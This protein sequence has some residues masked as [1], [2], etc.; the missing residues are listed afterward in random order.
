VEAELQRPPLSG[1]VYYNMTGWLCRHFGLQVAN[2]TSGDLLGTS[3]LVRDCYDGENNRVFFGSY[4]ALPPFTSCVILDSGPPVIEGSSLCNAQMAVLCQVPLDNV[5]LETTTKTSIRHA[6]KVSHTTVTITDSTTLTTSTEFVL[7]PTTATLTSL[8]TEYGAL[9]VTSTIPHG[10]SKDHQKQNHDRNRNYEKRE[11]A[12]NDDPKYAVC[13]SSWNGYRIVNNTDVQPQDTPQ[14]ACAAAGLNLGNVTNDE[15][16]GIKGLIMACSAQSVVFEAWY[17]YVPLCGYVFGG[18][19]VFVYDT[20]GQEGACLGAPFVLC[21]ASP[22][23]ITTST[24]S[25]GPFSTITNVQTVVT[26]TETTDTTKVITDVVTETETESIVTD[27]IS[28]P[29]TRLTTIT[30]TETVTTLTTTITECQQ[31]CHLC[32]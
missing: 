3:Q 1:G 14:A 16:E 13:T 19:G 6:T 8:A 7:D 4:E 24:V 27:T 26:F 17:G 25:T 30:L 2:L 9:T 18:P 29:L 5:S 23:L 22:P 20:P 10:H 28:I 21:K 12:Q 15:L 31:S 11:Y 32:P